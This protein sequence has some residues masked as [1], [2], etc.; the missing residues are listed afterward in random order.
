M[1]EIITASW[2]GLIDGYS[3]GGDIEKVASLFDEMSRKDLVS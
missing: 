1:P 3:K 2:N